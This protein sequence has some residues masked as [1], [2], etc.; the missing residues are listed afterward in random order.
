MRT[1]WI[2]LAGFLGAVSRYHFEGWVSNRLPTAFPWGTFAVN[3]T[4]CF[5]LGFVFTLLTERFLPHPDLRTAITIGFVGAYTTFSTF[6]FETIRLGEDGAVA[7][8]L[9]NV[10]ASVLAG[11]AAVWL[12]TVLGRAL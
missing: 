12:G 5:L 1:V 11:I 7:L 6:A 2:G 10:L 8:A 4:G 3:V 9:S